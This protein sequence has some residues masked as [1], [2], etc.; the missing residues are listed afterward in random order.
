MTITT[1]SLFTR[2][3]LL[4]FVMFL[5]CCS[6]ERPGEG[7]SRNQLESSIATELKVFYDISSLPAYFENVYNAQV[8]SYDT[9]WKNDD[10]FNGKYSFLK[11]NADSSLLIF[12]KKGKGVINRIWTPTPT[13][14]TLDF[15]IDD[16]EP[17]FSIKF[18]DLFSGRQFPFVAPL[19]GNQLGGFYCYLPI[20]FEKSCKII[21]R[22]KKI[23]FHQIQ[24]RLYPAETKVK[25]FSMEL[26]NEEKEAL[27]KISKLW[28]TSEKSVHNFYS[29]EME[30]SNKRVEVR[31]GASETVFETNT[32]GRLLGIEIEP[33]SVFEGLNKNLD[34]RITWDNEKYPSVFCPVA[35]FFGY[36]FGTSSMQS[37][38]LG[39]QGEKNYC[40]FPMPFDE[41]AKIELISRDENI[42]ADV[43]TIN[44][45]VWYSRDRRV[46]ELEGKFYTAWNDNVPSKGKHHV[47]L[48]LQGK[49]HYVGTILL[50]QGLKAGMT[51]FFEGDDSTAVD[52]NFRM[53][54]T[55]SEDYFNGGWYALLDRW[56]S[57]MSLPLHGALDYSLPFAR[58]G[59]YRIFLSDKISFQN[60]FYHSIEHGPIGSA[61]PVKYT[62]VGLYYSDSP[63]MATTMPS[64][65]LTA[66]VTPDTLIIYPQLMDYN[67][68]ED[69]AIK[70]TWQF[71]TGGESYFF[72]VGDESWIRISLEEIPTGS[73]SLFFDLH[74]K[75]DGC[76]FSLWQRQ[77][78]LSSWISTEQPSEER[79]KDLYVCD[80]DVGDF[81]NTI[82]VRFKTQARN[83]SLLLHRITLV[84]K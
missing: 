57:K 10:G 17:T 45:K 64:N 27:Q 6:K 80:L 42:S 43:V 77:T 12:D 4:V 8:S 7:T 14:D 58:T 51:L 35:D 22:G 41:S 50:S 30:E 65:E 59:G 76:V 61:F 73:Y 72:T 37:L 84:K 70:T 75:P 34:I 24:Y 81:K 53:H 44:V 69:L 20:P 63:S 19:C 36:A 47:F 28:N 66:V 74:K 46:P 39:T 5:I 56:D 48:D 71:G 26:T 16:D 29:A 3:I 2:F 13:V 31:A 18:S 62:S 21:F 23:Q 49:G 68:A 82:T 11:R 9:T 38:L 55:G 52:G 78:Q 79:V 1:R 83:N 25:S 67:I 33:A 60:S 54:G 15:F 32:G 40:Y